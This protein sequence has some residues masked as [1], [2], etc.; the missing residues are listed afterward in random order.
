MTRVTKLCD[1]WVTVC[2]GKCDGFNFLNYLINNICDG[3]TAQNPKASGKWG[4]QSAEFRAAR[5]VHRR[6][7]GFGGLAQC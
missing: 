3:V 7:S 4:V 2:D 6:R 1:G 5:Q